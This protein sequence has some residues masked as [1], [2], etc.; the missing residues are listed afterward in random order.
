MRYWDIKQ[1]KIT[2]S[3]YEVNKLIKNGWELLDFFKPAK[4]PLLFVLGK[5]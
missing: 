3:G 4:Q 5:R 2:G 1:I